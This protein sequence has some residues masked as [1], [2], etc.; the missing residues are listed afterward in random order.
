[1]VL[2]PITPD[3]LAIYTQH[4]KRLGEGGLPQP[5]G[6]Y[7]EDRKNFQRDWAIWKQSIRPPAGSIYSTQAVIEATRSLD[8]WRGFEHSTWSLESDTECRWP[9][10]LGIAL[11]GLKSKTQ[12]YTLDLA[13]PA[14][15][16]LSLDYSPT[17]PAVIWPDSKSGKDAGLGLPALLLWALCDQEAPDWGTQEKGWDRMGWSSPTPCLSQALG[18]HGSMDD[19]RGWLSADP[20]AVDALLVI[21]KVSVQLPTR[22]RMT[23]IREMVEWGCLGTPEAWEHFYAHVMKRGEQSPEASKA[24]VAEAL[25]LYARVRGERLEQGLPEPSHKKPKPRF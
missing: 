21:P 5:F 12:V 3:A 25:E 9:S 14:L 2:S 18:P 6:L 24:L 17:V 23:M 15:I 11:A 4:A 13:L 19:W 16:G 7:G 10:P 1:M 22:R 8:R 20:Q